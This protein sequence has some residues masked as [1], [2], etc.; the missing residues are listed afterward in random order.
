[1]L[2]NKSKFFLLSWVLKCSQS[3]SGD[4]STSETVATF[5]LFL[6]FTDFVMRKRVYSL[7]V[8]CGSVKASTIHPKAYCCRSL[9]DRTTTWHV[10][11]CSKCWKN[12]GKCLE[13]AVL[14]RMCWMY[15]AQ[16]EHWCWADSYHFTD[17]TES[18]SGREFLS[19][20]HAVGMWSR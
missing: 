3:P 19:L 7:P 8:M 5:T 16:W 15:C 17:D 20:I 10:V 2:M 9:I 14:K 1:M 11:P 4:L 12:T 6:H 18:R 13:K